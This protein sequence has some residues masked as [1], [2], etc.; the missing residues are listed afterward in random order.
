MSFILAPLPFMV[1]VFVQRVKANGRKGACGG[2][3]WAVVGYVAGL[4]WDALFYQMMYLQATGKWEQ[5]LG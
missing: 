3:G 5:Y 4:G 2:L 1:V